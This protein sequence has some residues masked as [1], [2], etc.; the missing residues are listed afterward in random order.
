MFF[1][2]M[3]ALKPGYPKGIINKEINTSAMDCRVWK[4]NLQSKISILAKYFFITDSLQK[5]AHF[6]NSMTEVTT[7]TF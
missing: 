6:I 3:N 4:S 7:P 5:L 1:I 2:F